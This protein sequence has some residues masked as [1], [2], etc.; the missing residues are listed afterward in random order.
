MIFGIVFLVLSFILG[1]SISM[2]FDIKP[3]LQRVAFALTI[4]LFLSTWVVFTVSFL[5]L[6]LSYFSIVISMLVIG[7]FSYLLTIKNE[8]KSKSIKL[9]QSLN[10][11][12]KKIEL[13]L[14][15]ILEKINIK[16]VSNSLKQSPQ[17]LVYFFVLVIYLIHFAAG[18]RADAYENIKCIDGFCSDAPFHMS[19]MNSFVYRNNFPPENP[20]LAGTKLAYPFLNDF[21]SAI[22]IKAGFPLLLPIVLP[23]LLFVFSFVTLA[24]Y[25][26]RDVS[27]NKLVTSFALLL[28]FFG[29][30]G[31]FNIVTILNGNTLGGVEYR[32]SPDFNSIS[33]VASYPYFNFAEVLTNIFIPQRSYLV[34]FPIALIVLTFFYRNAFGAKKLNKKELLLCGTLVGLLP[35]FHAHSFIILSFVGGVLFLFSRKKEWLYFIV[36]LVLFS[37]PQ[38]LWIMSVPK[39]DNFFGF[40]FND[41]FWNFDSR[42]AGFDGI[43]MTTLSH[44]VFWIRTLGFPFILGTIGIFLMLK[45]P[46]K[47]IKE[48]KSILLFFVPF[49]LLFIAANVVRF[50]PS[51]GNNNKITLY[52]LL[53]MCIFS[54]LLLEKLFKKNI[55]G[56]ALVI[57]IIFL[58]SLQFIFYANQNLIIAQRDYDSESYHGYY[59][60]IFDKIDFTVADWIVKNTDEKSIFLTEDSMNHLV[61]A[62][63]GRSVVKGVYVW[64]IGVLVNDPEADINQIYASGDCDLAKKYGVDY[65]FIGPYEASIATYDF[66]SSSNYA[67][68][69]ELDAKGVKFQIYKVLC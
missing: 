14:E 67:R 52:F 23:N 66:S 37:L 34:G 6:S 27:K 51:F 53:F 32:L 3:V 55:F 31:F 56:K 4:G 49:A 18:L 29:G 48:I 28:F 20:L 45:K 42:L 10:R 26:I 17:Y 33:S 1:Y 69:Y 30:I 11:N 9:K 47:R 12:L 7:S 16:N 5:L 60:Y 39:V 41:G 44:I 38:V 57:L 40:V 59:P 64:D 15:N 68:V 24:F 25:F 21:L 61:P 13:R 65:V 35:L 19:I 22:L 8:S 58:S 63:S 50:Q 36:P 43:A 46:M 54:S 2:F 62:L